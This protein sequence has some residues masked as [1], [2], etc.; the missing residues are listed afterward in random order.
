MLVKLLTGRIHEADIEDER[1][2]EKS[3]PSEN[4]CRPELSSEGS[5]LATACITL[6]NHARR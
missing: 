1:L 3:I 4:R 6:L 2:G 5:G